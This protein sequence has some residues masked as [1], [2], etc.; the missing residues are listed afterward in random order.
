MA[1]PY[2]PHRKGE[3]Y[4]EIPFPVESP[5]RT[6]RPTKVKRASGGTCDLMATLGA[7]PKVAVRSP[8][9]QVSDWTPWP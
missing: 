3:K 6:P 2:P 8:D 9:E 4:R 1:A 7:A 5:D